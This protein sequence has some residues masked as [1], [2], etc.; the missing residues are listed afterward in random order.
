MRGSLFSG[1]GGDAL[2]LRKG[3]PIGTSQKLNIKNGPDYK[4]VKKLLLAAIICQECSRKK[5]GV[6]SGKIS[7]SPKKGSIGR[8][9]V[10]KVTT[11]KSIHVFG[12]GGE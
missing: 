3:T 7:L 8:G 4:D 10:E 12:G 9:T 11:I 2:E 5:E 6:N 1:G